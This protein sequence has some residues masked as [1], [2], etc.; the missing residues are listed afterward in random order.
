M[1]D[2][3]TPRR[4]PGSHPHLPDLHVREV[5]ETLRKPFQISSAYK[6]LTIA[7]VILGVFISIEWQ[8]PVAKSPI[9]ADYPRELGRNTIKRMEAEQKDLKALITDLRAHLTGLQR[10]AATRKSALADLNAQIESQRV[11]AG[12]S[13]LVGP[14]LVLTLDDSAAKVIP[15]GDDASNYLVHDYDLRDAVSILWESG[16]EAIAVNDER[17]VGVSSIYCVGSTI[18]VNDTRLSPP[19]KIAAI[20]APSMEDALNS[21]S[22]LQKLKLNVR[23]YGVQYKVAG[24]KDVRVPAFTGRFS[25]RFARTG[26]S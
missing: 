17:L 25:G 24:A 2:S 8:A 3:A 16:A 4:L 7:A 19:Y 23:Q 11:L 12:L 6:W 9:T 15:P 13:P 14:G 5:G 20:G 1:A 22:R 26:G 21:S 18:L 10:E